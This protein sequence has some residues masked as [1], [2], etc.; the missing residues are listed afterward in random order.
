[1]E[2]TMETKTSS[3]EVQ[4]QNLAQEALDAASDSA[5]PP[6]GESVQQIE[7]PKVPLHEHTALRQRAQQAEIEKA[8]LEGQL[9]VL[10]QQQ[11]RQ[12]PPEQSPL[13]LEIARQATE[14]ISEDE[15]VIPAKILRAEKQY[16][17]QVANQQAQ[18]QSQQALLAQ[19]AASAKS[20]MTTHTDFVD[21][22]KVGEALLTPGEYLDCK[23]AGADFGDVIYAKCKAAIE[24]NAP[25][26]KSDSTPPPATPKT[27]PSESKVESREIPS[28]SEILNSVD[29]ITAAAALL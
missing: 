5:T 25:K 8:R 28:R 17:R 18:Q 14:G 4:D 2:E 6:A 21:V 13:E 15:M 29:P 12:A 24:R 11:T 19:Q 7:E 23:N 9:A 16:E 20:A 27:K 3:E 26:V 10:Q 22:V 1:M